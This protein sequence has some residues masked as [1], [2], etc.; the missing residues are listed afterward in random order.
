[1]NAA[2]L[3]SVLVL[4]GACLLC[5]CERKPDVSNPL[6]YRSAHLTFDYPGNW[7]VADDIASEASHHL[8]I[9]TPGE[10]LVVLQ[11]QEETLFPGASEIAKSFSDAAREEMPFGQLSESTFTEAGEK[12]GF[13]LLKEEFSITV[14]GETVAHQRVYATRKAGGRVQLIIF[15]VAAEDLAKVQAGFDL[16]SGSLAIPEATEPTPPKAEA[17]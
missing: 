1:M 16:I 14:A 11:S 5:A 8:I 2:R 15:Q 4:S 12:A 9:E 13:R 10:A 7:K 3:L 6:S 17:P